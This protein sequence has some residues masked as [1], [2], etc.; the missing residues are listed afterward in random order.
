MPANA[1]EELYNLILDA[2]YWMLDSRI[3]QYQESRNQHQIFF[4]SGLSGLG[5]MDHDFYINFSYI[6]DFSKWT[7]R[8]IRIKNGE[9]ISSLKVHSSWLIADRSKLFS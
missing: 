2:R 7:T 5:L 1:L 4:G 6:I 3:I 8:L 9:G